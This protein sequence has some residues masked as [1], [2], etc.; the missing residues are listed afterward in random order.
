MEKG[1]IILSKKEIDRLATIH[2]VIDKRLTQIAAA[3]ILHLTDRQIRR[4]LKKV[5]TGGDKAVAHG[6][7]GKASSKKMPAV[8]EN[9]ILSIVEK[10]Y[11]D[12]G[13][14][15]ASEKLL[16]RN[17][18][19][20]SREKLRQLMIS[21]DIW[22]PNVKSRAQIHQ[23]RERKS[24]YGEL[25]QMDGSQHD[26]LE[27]RA[28]KMTL[29]AYIDDA[30]NKVFARFYEYEGVFSAMDSFKRYIN[31]FGLP[32]CVYFDRHSTY[33][34]TRQPSLEEELK[35]EFAKTQFAR[36][37]SELGVNRIYARS[38]QAKG[39]IERT[40]ETLQD[41][42]IKEMRLAKIS[43]IDAA[44]NFIETYLDKFNTRFSLAPLK[45]SNLHKSNPQNF[46]L[47]EIFCIKEHR[48]I[49]NNYSFQLKNRLFIISKPS[50]TMK[51]QRI[52]VMKM[53]DGRILAK[54]K[55]KYLEIVEVTSK[56]L[57]AIAKV[58]KATQRFLRKQR[59]VY[60]PPLNH[61]WR[62]Y[63]IKDRCYSYA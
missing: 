18:I 54:L 31:K 41:R 20:V 3:E 52:C 40:F 1:I 6:N 33:K 47:D 32:C 22:H 27:G 63:S 35:G 50:I 29:M 61:P 57:F 42:L 59:V 2:R 16:E 30:T 12:F 4:I 51:K 13:P 53:F 9:R 56:D 43:N 15:L 23:W 14:L 45:K 24:F 34:T 36:A 46:A 25:I 55:N 10:E 17:K 26:W 60:K 21:R 38:P 62:H 48:T 7:R 19:H 49:A 5:K 44:N 28:S 8:M 11:Y 37:L 58:Q 39:R